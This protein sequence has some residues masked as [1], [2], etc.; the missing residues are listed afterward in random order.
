MQSFLEGR[1]LD[2]ARV[3]DVAQY[4]ESGDVECVRGIQDEKC[5]RC[6]NEDRAYFYT[7]HCA[8]CN[9]AC[10]YCRKCIQLGRISSC[11]T[12]IRWCG[13]RAERPTNHT[14]VPLHL[15]DAQQRASDE[16]IDSLTVRRNHL[17]HAVCGA[18]KTEILFQPVLH[19]LQQQQ[20][21][22]IATPRTDVVLELYPRLQQAFPNT[23]VQALY[24][25][26]D[27]GQR[28]SP[29]IVATTHQ[30][31]R[32]QSAFD[33]IIV[34]EADA[35]PYTYDA[36][37][38]RAVNKAKTNEAPIAFVTATPS[39]KLLT[40]CKKEQWGYS[41]LP[42]RYH[43]HLLPVP[44]IVV[45]RRLQKQFA[46]NKL[47]K[48]LHDWLHQRL[49]KHEPFLLFLP[50]IALIEQCLPLI[51]SVVPQV[52][53]VHAEDEERKEKVLKL[54]GGELQG[55][56]TST[57]LER[58]IT[59]TN[60]QVAVVCADDAIFDAGAL[61]Q[62][63]GRVGRHKQY[64]SGDIAFFAESITIAMDAAIADIKRLNAVVV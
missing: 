50:T 34:D 29:L 25:G 39:R 18:G 40:Q 56:V 21:V 6:L 49:T 23:F 36:M 32:F 33:V 54:R 15:S 8:V 17:L 58:G 30:L 31:L 47:P 10:T 38:Q 12:L 48:A 7:F 35:F 59:I 3:D 61:V 37:L 52:E 63:S 1:I 43:G 14:L 62:I 41:F 28:F 9:G 51:Q 45:V 60:V 24:G 27:V 4:I 64:A 22:C 53:A 46:Q 57:I 19:A 44:R 20:R 2:A 42:R 16:L 26:A 11:T 55:L 5:M 13:K